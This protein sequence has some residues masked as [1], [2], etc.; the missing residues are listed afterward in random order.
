MCIEGVLIVEIRLDITQRGITADP[1]DAAL[2]DP[3][4][5]DIEVEVRRGVAI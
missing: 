4:N 1:D 5:V 3:G 2:A